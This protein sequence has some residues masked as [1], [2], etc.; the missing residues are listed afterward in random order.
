MNGHLA[1][2]WDGYKDWQKDWEKAKIRLKDAED[3][4]KKANQSLAEHPGIEMANA[5]GRADAERSEAQKERQKTRQRLIDEASDFD[6]S[7]LSNAED[8]VRQAEAEEAAAEQE[9]RAAEAALDKSPPP[10]AQPPPAQ[11]S[12]VQK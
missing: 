11:P 2:A 5:L 4:V 7:K 3:A 8:E 9:L 10:P 12:P 1:M 6:K